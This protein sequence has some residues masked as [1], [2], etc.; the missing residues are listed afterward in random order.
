MTG[1]EILDWI[2]VILLLLGAA[3]SFAAGVGLV[4]F[5]D[6]LSRMHTAAKPQVMGL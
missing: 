3:L 4:R 6:L 1:T 5:P 2:S